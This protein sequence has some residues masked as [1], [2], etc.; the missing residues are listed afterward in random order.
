MYSQV[1]HWVAKENNMENGG[2]GGIEWS[3]HY[4]KGD[5]ILQTETKIMSWMKINY[6][7]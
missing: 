7:K 6:V 1:N 4:V 2:G 3:Y 5:L